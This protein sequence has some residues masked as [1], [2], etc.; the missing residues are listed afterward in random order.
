MTRSV[1]IASDDPSLMD[2]VRRV[3]LRDELCGEAGDGVVYHGDGV[4]HALIYPLTLAPEEWEGW[5]TDSPETPDPRTL[6]TLMLECG[7]AEWI[8]HIGAVIAGE[9]EAPV[10]IIDDDTAWDAGRVDPARLTL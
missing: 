4:P 5:P 2:A 3:L 10:W 8:A 6:T 9:V 1:I 7:S